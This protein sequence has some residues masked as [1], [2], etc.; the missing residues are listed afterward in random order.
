V[1]HKVYPSKTHMVVSALEKDTGPFWSCEEGE[2]V[3]GSEYPYQ[4][5]IRALIY[6][7]NNTRPDIAFTVNLL[8]RYSATPTMCH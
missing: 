6:L 7:A 1:L 2:E 3:L 4:S 5:A 8:V